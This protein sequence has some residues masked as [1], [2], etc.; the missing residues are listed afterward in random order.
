MQE[1][2]PAMAVLARF[3]VNAVESGKHAHGRQPEAPS[4]T[5]PDVRPAGATFTVTGPQQMPE[6]C[7][8]STQ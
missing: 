1:N 6:P 5:R 7:E 4:A 2:V 3:F 8:P